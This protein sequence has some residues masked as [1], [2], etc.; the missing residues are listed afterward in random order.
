M[1]RRFKTK[2]SNDDQMTLQITSMADIFM[3][4]LVFLLKS[5]ST[6]MINVSPSAGVVLPLAHANGALAEALK[7]E[8]SE[9]AIQVEGKPVAKLEAFLFPKDASERASSSGALNEAL[10][11]E[12]KRQALIAEKNSDVKL[13]SKILIMAS[14]QTPYATLKAVLASAAGNGFSDFKLVVAKKEE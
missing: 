13:D 5:F 2:I 7:L 12:R 3:I 6:S 14:Q 1:R 11:S 10:S 9:T 4:V 8:I